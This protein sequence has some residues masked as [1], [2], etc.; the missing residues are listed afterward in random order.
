L[1]A[2]A[3]IPRRSAIDYATAKGALVV[4]GRQLG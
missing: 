2:R 3:T 1:E 4:V